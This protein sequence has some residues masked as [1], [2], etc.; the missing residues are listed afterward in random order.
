MPCRS[1]TCD[2]EGVVFRLQAHNRTLATDTATEGS[3]WSAA[4]RRFLTSRYCLSNDGVSLCCRYA[5]GGLAETA[6]WLQVGNAILPSIAFVWNPLRLFE[7]HSFSYAAQTQAYVDRF[8]DPLPFDMAYRLAQCVLTLGLSIL[9][10]PILPISPM[11]GLFGIVLHYWTDQYIALRHSI[12][13][14]AFDVESLAP[15]NQII[16][17]LLLVQASF[18]FYEP[19]QPHGHAW[20]RERLYLLLSAPCGG[21]MSTDH[22]PLMYFM[23]HLFLSESVLCCFYLFLPTAPLLALSQIF[24]LFLAR[25]KPSYQRQLS[26]QVAGTQ[27]AKN[28]QES[29]NHCNLQISC[30]WY[31]VTT[32]YHSGSKY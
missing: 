14:V 30:I 21:S 26:R 23:Q 7:Y 5:R 28:Q 25:I 15:L 27:E 12:A 16:R 24:Y 31:T 20:L 13:P 4:P 1:T 9:Y 8:L 19:A 6:F 3:N 29:F 17:F 2:H 32:Q 11:I 10:A 22:V 18:D